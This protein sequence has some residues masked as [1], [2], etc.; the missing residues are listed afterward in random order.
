M[1]NTTFRCGHCGNLM[2]VGNQFLGQQVACPTCKQ[3]VVAPQP[4]PTTPEPSPEPAQQPT[5]FPSL[6]L[7]S[8][9]ESIFSTPSNDDLFDDPAPMLAPAV[10]YRPEPAADPNATLDEQ[11]APVLSANDLAAPP[12]EITPAPANLSWPNQASEPA[13]T[14]EPSSRPSEPTSRNRKNRG[15]GSNW[16]IIFMIPLVSY[17]I[18]ATALLLYL[19][20]RLETL[21][22][23][24]SNPTDNMPDINGDYP[25][26]KKVGPNGKPLSWKATD[27]MNAIALPSSHKV[28]LGDTIVVGNLEVT[29]TVVERKRVNV[30][31]LGYPTPAPCLSDSLVL[32]LKLKNLSTEYAFVP[33]ED[34]FDRTWTGGKIPNMPP[35]DAMPLTVLQAGSASFVG[36]PAGWRPRV[37]SLAMEKKLERAWMEG[38]PSPKDVKPLLPGE[39]QTTFTATNGQ[40]ETIITTLLAHKG[41]FF[42]RVHLRQGP[43]PIK[44]RDEPV[45]STTV[46]GVS[47]AAKDVKN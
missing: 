30:F 32:H 7:D 33:L 26:G 25:G 45:P 23:S 5:A 18:L 22:T 3:V 1:Q 38:R 16:L 41:D 28:K 37:V 2:A 15:D 9:H 20:N 27:D 21:R 42:W 31:V 40:K 35:L 29:P 36:G 44:G 43:I 6:S 10:E 46:V 14:E 13:V 39:T 12:N 8:E 11:P 47:F 34:S 19:W 24:I 4:Q 17:S